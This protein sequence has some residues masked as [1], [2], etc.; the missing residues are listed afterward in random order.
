M[1]KKK[2]GFGLLFLFL[3]MTCEE[4][5]TSLQKMSNP[6]CVTGAVHLGIN[7]KTLG[8]ST[9]QLQMFSNLLGKNHAL[10]AELWECRFHEAHFMAGFVEEPAL[11]TEDQLEK[12]AKDFD[13]WAICDHICSTVIRRTTFAY[14]KISDWANRDEEFVKR[15]AFSLM[16][17]MAVHDKKANDQT[18]VDLLPVAEKHAGD[19]RNFVKKAVNWAIRQIGKR[20]ILLNEKAIET[21]LRIKAGNTRSGRWI[22]ADA[23]RELQSEAVF[24]RLWEK[25]HPTQTIS[26]QT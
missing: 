24:K 5:I 20:S 17:V 26:S 19:D 1:T 21:A 16:A 10:A 3:S 6:E 14:K 12:W 9:P 25:A 15:A 22:A 11:V 2:A 23:L 8:I 18:F 13:N 4:I 7:V